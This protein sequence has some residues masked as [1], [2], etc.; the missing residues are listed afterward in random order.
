MMNVCKALALA[1]ACLLSACATI[2]TSSSQQVKV[3]SNPQ[4]AKV[5]T[6]VKSTKDGVDA[7]AK[8]SEVGVTPMTVI[9]ARKDGAIFLE[10][11]G[12]APAEVPLERTM[13]PWVWGDIVLTSLLSTSIDTS[14]GAAKKYDPDEY[15]VELKPATAAAPPSSPPPSPPQ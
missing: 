3:D 12:Y 7:I 6:A 8:R 5:F 9:I 14:T 13:N 15:L 4:G 10:K 11:E 2:M 1:A